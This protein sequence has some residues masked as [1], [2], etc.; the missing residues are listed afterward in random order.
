MSINSSAALNDSMNLERSPA[1]RALQREH[2]AQEAREQA[3]YQER[4]DAIYEEAVRGDRDLSYLVDRLIGS[5]E[6][7]GLYHQLCDLLDR[8]PQTLKKCPGEPDT[9]DQHLTEQGFDFE[10]LGRDM[11]AL[12]K[13]M[14]EQYAED[15]AE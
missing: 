4:Y 7:G 2:E 6:D 8:F 10:Q 13:R 11:W 9:F 3:E 15:A 1:F 14:A 12:Y 5:T